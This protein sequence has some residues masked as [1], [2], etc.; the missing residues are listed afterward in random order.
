MYKNAR[1]AH[2]SL[3][4]QIPESS[5]EALSYKYSDVVTECTFMGSTC[6]SADFTSF[7]HHEYGRC[8]TFHSNR[9][10]TRVGAMTQLRLLLTAN[11]YNS[12]GLTWA[13]F[14][15]TERL[16]FKV[17]VHTPEQ[18]P[19][20]DRHGLYIAPGHQTAIGVKMFRMERLD[21]PYG[22]CTFNQ[23]SEDNFYSEYEYTMGS[24]LDSCRQKYTVER[25]GCAHPAWRKAHNDSY[26]GITI[27][28]FECLLSLRGDQTNA[29]E[30]Q[31]NLN[32]LRDC[33]CFDPC[34]ETRITAT[35]SFSSYPALLYSV[36]TGTNSQFEKLYREQGGGR[37]TTTTTTTMSPGEDPDNEV[38]C[39]TTLSASIRDD[40]L[41]A[42]D[43]FNL[44]KI[45][46]GDPICKVK[47]TPVTGGEHWHSNWPCYYKMCNR[48]NATSRQGSYECKDVLPYIN[49]VPNSI[50]VPGWKG[51][52]KGEEPTLLTQC[53]STDDPPTVDNS[54]PSGTY[55]SVTMVRWKL[56]IWK[57]GLGE[58]LGRK[59]RMADTDG[60]SA[61][62]NATKTA[63]PS[64]NT[65]I[66]NPGLGSC[67][68]W[69][70]NFDS[71][72]ECNKWYQKNGL[73]LQV[74]VDSL[75]YTK[76]TQGATLSIL[77]VL[78]EIGGNAGLWLGMSVISCIELIGLVWL[79][80]YQIC[81]GGWRKEEKK[82]EGVDREKKRRDS[83]SD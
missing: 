2:M 62:L 1:L 44:L 5:R 51:W 60:L 19:D 48:P 50:D 16:G 36:G 28:Q 63:T 74:F 38:G 70:V 76:M 82:E 27:D 3:S 54:C 11:A 41:Y 33:E 59:K 79:I 30:T 14:P 15:S 17:V 10:V 13:N 45:C 25:C 81:T 8:F 66:D 78:I 71:I 40:V 68:T 46:N 61:W 57:V 24:C 64:N 20:I 53:L 31:R 4:S 29:N 83:L 69:N 7:F 9:S 43:T 18:F 22:R 75:Q 73:I 56:W 23:S 72:E 77:S 37:D 47:I 55:M 39:F 32:A 34:N 65:I 52:E 80:L 26:C 67:D 21:K 49:F 6:T 12:R 42:R 58:A 35:I